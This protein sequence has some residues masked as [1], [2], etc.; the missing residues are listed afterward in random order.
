MVRLYLISGNQ[1]QRKNRA[2]KTNPKVD[3][4]API[5]HQTQVTTTLKNYLLTLQV[6]VQ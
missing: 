2:K 3:L 5:T 1:L 6:K 4:S